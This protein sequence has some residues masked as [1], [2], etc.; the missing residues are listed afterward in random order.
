MSKLTEE[1]RELI[2]KCYEHAPATVSIAGLRNM[3]KTIKKTFDDP[4]LR[5]EIE[6][7]LSEQR[8]T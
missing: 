2:S 8:E 1:H 6:K 3:F 4:K 5:A 7:R